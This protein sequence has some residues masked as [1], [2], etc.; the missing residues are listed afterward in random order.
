M[1]LEVLY[2]DQDYIAVHKP[3]GL[4][5][6]K[7]KLD[8]DDDQAVVQLLR[9]QI[10]QKV[11]PVH[12][13]DKPTS[14]VLF[15]A[16]SGEA[17]QKLAEEFSNKKIEKKYLAIVRGLFTEE[18]LL[19][20]PLKIEIKKEAE[21]KLQEA[22]T[23]F[24]PVSSVEIP[25]QIDRYPT[26]RFSLIQAYPKTGRTHQIRRHL[27]HLN[28]PIIGDVNHGNGKH[29]RYFSEVL[30]IKGLMLSCT[31]ISFIHPTSQKKITVTST[32]PTSFKNALL[33]LELTYDFAT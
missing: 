33:K 22:Q 32:L 28:F 29:N 20:Y 30:G 16:T 9:N 4:L 12:R 14:G 15:L 31:E 11:F 21:Q 8:I 10:K 2:Q 26:S 5:V 25:V 24:K 6:H 3:P 13:L 23:L 18:V 7:T 19:D 27:K 1:T 17:A